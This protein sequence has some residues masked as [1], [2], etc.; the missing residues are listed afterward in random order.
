MADS[1]GVR[2]LR[3][4]ASRWLDRVQGGES[5]T[6]TDR[7]KPIARLVPL[8]EGAPDWQQEWVEHGR[9]EPG[10]R[11][12]PFSWGGLPTF[13]LPNGIASSQQLLDEI[14]GDR[15]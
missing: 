11:S 4:H 8:G 13:A 3:Q 7:G 5:F 6:I 14:R 15:L 2:E 12:A 9:M 1:I 10:D